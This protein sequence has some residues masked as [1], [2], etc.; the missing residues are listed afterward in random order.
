MDARR[1]HRIREDAL[2]RKDRRDVEHRAR[3]L[4]REEPPDHGAKLRRVHRV[5]RRFLHAGE[6]R[7]D[8]VDRRLVL[9]H[10]LRRDVG[11]VLEARADHVER[12]LREVLDEIR[13]QVEDLLARVGVGLGTIDIELARARRDLAVVEAAADD[14]RVT[15]AMGLEPGVGLVTPRDLLAAVE[16]PRRREHLSVLGAI[17]V[18]NVD[19]VI[20]VEARAREFH[21]PVGRGRLPR[22]GRRDVEDALAVLRHHGAVDRVDAVLDG[23]LAADRAEHPGLELPVVARVE[24]DDRVVL[25]RVIRGLG[26]ARH[27]PERDDEDVRCFGRLL[28]GDALPLVDAVPVVLPVA[29]EVLAVR[30]R[31]HAQPVDHDVVRVGRF[32]RGRDV[33]ERVRE[34]PL[35]ET[36]LRVDGLV[37]DEGASLRSGDRVLRAD[38]RTRPLRRGRVGRGWKRVE[39]L[40]FGYRH[41]CTLLM[42]RSRF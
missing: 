25:P 26:L 33:L 7:G 12:G 11:R 15:R 24:E 28:T 23:K 37:V 10:E 2:L 40:L 35:E 1:L 27:A 42:N 4:E 22:A 6:L 32:L 9:S 13:S 8:R 17:G 31:A 20:G 39:V 41:R 30:D 3:V 19:P 29:D 5:E 38:R 14:G 34:Q 16:D 21:D 36:G 18:A